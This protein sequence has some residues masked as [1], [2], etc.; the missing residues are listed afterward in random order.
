MADEQHD[1]PRTVC[2]P[3]RSPRLAQHPDYHPYTYTLSELRLQDSKDFI[4]FQLCRG[5]LPQADEVFNSI[6][7]RFPCMDEKPNPNN[8]SSY[9][10]CVEPLWVSCT[11]ITSSQLSV[12]SE[13]YH[14]YKE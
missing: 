9:A 2:Y 3:R 4:G 6:S 8:V 5:S 7:C 14:E 12:T 10:P 13:V 1:H 11:V